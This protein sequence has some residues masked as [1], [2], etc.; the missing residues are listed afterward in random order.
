MIL[1]NV[2]SIK[3]VSDLHLFLENNWEEQHE[4]LKGDS[5]I[6]FIT[7]N[8]SLLQPLVTEGGCGLF[9]LGS[10]IHDFK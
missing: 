8:D 4:H 2:Q 10:K 3:P 5:F 9:R 7:K 6:D 1:R